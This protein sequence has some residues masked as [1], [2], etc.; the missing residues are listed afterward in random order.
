MNMLPDYNLEIEEP[1]EPRMNI[2][3][4]LRTIFAPERKEKQAIPAPEWPRPEEN[5]EPIPAPEWPQREPAETGEEA[6]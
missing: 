4:P 1:K 6:R 3:E 5:P 2:G